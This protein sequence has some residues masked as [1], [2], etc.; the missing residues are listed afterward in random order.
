MEEPILGVHLSIAGGIE[1]VFV[2]ARRLKIN[3][4]QIFLSSPRVWNVKEPEPDQIIFFKEQVKDYK[5]CNIHAPYLL[6]FATENVKLFNDS[7]ARAVKD[8]KIMNSLGINYYVVH[9]GSSPVKSGLKRVKQAVKD[10]FEKVSNG[11]IL[12]ENLSGEKNDVGKNMDEILEITDGFRDK[13]GICID[14]CHLFSSGIDIRKVEELDKFYEFLVKNDLKD[15]LKMI[16]VNDSKKGLGSNIDR[17]EHI[18]MG[19][20]GKTG[21]FNLLH[22]PFFRSLPLILETPKEDNADEKNL[23]LLKTLFNS[24][25]I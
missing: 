10:V 13:V 25:E 3:C 11:V 24:K 12:I 9:P 2:E 8:M 21:F 19:E 22:H 6:N 17:H 5:F 15:R 18:G 4:F 16:H 1:N 23:L 7:V 20:I 14:T